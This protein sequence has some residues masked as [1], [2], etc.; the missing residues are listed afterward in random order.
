MGAGV[1]LDKRPP[2]QRGVVE[3]AVLGA[4]ALVGVLPAA[5]QPAA[6]VG[7]GVDAFGTWWFYNWIR[8]AIEHGGD[9]S[10]TRAF[11]WPL[12][13]EIF[14]HTGNNFV[15]AVLSAPLQWILGQHYSAPWTWAILVGNALTF[16]PLAREVLGDEDRSFAA[17]LLWMVNPYAMFEITA[18]RPTQAFLWFVPAVPY[19][20]LRLERGGFEAVKLGVAAALAGWSYWFSSF[21]VAT[22]CVPLLLR[23]P[24]PWR[25][26]LLAGA[27]AVAIVAPAAI[28]MARLWESGATPGGAP[29][30]AQSIFALP[31][32][33]GNSVGASL[34]GLLLMEFHGAPLFTNLAWSLPLLGAL[35]LTWRRW[36]WWA[37][38]GLCAFLA[39]GPELA[40]GQATPTAELPVVSV[41]YMV[42]YKYLPFFNRLWF[43]YRFASAAFVAA[44]LLVAAALPAR[45][46]RASALSLAVLG[47][48]E[49]ARG[50][51]FPF[52]WHDVRCPPLLEAVAREGGAIMFLPFRIQHEGI[53]WQTV[54]RRPTFGGMGESA[55]V[56]WPRGYKGQL[57]IPAV[58]SLRTAVER[59]DPVRPGADTTP[60]VE[61]GY[62]WVILRR[63]LQAQEHGRLSQVPVPSEAVARVALV[64]ST[65]PVATGGP[66]VAWDLAGR[67]TPPTD[68]VPTGLEEDDWAFAAQP[69]WE[70]GL[71]ELGRL[72][73]REP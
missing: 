52:A 35:A 19:Y 63:D 30:P 28:P 36:R 50:K 57:S 17:S 59:P 20:L 24:L 68:F 9:P 49:Q 65:D 23:R 29:A 25:R 15:D 44:A 5:L 33:I 3:F 7:D 16:R 43:P 70:R 67:W 62:R 72:G 12:G 10:F 37:G 34:H 31:G 56:L 13:K 1:Y 6:M 55:P 69:A 51:I 71:S 39:I 45:W 61:L 40:A 46:V 47:L 8:L 11:F 32:A 41:P 42:L 14:T 58:R 18:G 64:L 73:R 27:V 21:F 66:L 26:L 54:F 4:I 38:L 2:V 60:L 53:I 48:A 22:L